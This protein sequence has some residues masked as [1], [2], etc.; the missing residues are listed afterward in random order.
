VLDYPTRH[1]AAIN[2]QYDATYTS[3]LPY[4]LAGIH[5]Q[6]EARVA[7]QNYIDHDFICKL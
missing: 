7:V 3:G 5:E 4:R 2:R 1:K 6:Y